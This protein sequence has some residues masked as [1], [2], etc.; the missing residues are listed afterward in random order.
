MHNQN[1]HVVY[2]PTATNADI[3]PDTQLTEAVEVVFR[4]DY[5]PYSSPGPEIVVSVY[6]EYTDP[7]GQRDDG[8]WPPV[9]VC[10][11]VAYEIREENGDVNDG[12]Y[13]YVQGD[14]EFA[15]DDSGDYP[16]LV[17]AIKH[18]AAKYVRLGDMAWDWNGK[19]AMHRSGGPV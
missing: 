15:P 7:N 9:A 6:G 12:D 16:G 1:W 11:Q 8:S 3:S 10:T 13:E 5:R 2:G 18:E 17:S 14:W 4:M 19:S